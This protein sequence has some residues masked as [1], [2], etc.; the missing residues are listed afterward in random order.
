[1]HPQTKEG[2]SARGS[3]QLLLQALCAPLDRALRSFH[4]VQRTPGKSCSGP[5]P[6]SACSHQPQ[7]ARPGN[8]GH[9]AG[10]AAIPCP[11]HGPEQR[12]PSPGADVGLAA[13][14]EDGE[15]FLQEP[16]GPSPWPARLWPCPAVPVPAEHG[17]PG[18]M[19][20][21]EPAG[22]DIL[23]WNTRSPACP[24]PGALPRASQSPARTRDIGAA[25]KREAEGKPGVNIAMQDSFYCRG[26]AAGAR[27]DSGAMAKGLTWLCWPR[28]SSSSSPGRVLD[29][30]APRAPWGGSG[31]AGMRQRWLSSWHGAAE[32]QS[33]A[34]L[35]GFSCTQR[36]VGMVG[37]CRG[38]S[39]SS[40]CSEAAL[41]FSRARSCH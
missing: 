20:C 41:G 16:R 4:G 22:S 32:E 24:A 21:P 34:M 28:G 40:L 12:Q 39:C 3:S 36:R 35:E 9:A 2:T 37:M 30:R 8:L 33:P 29:S 25:G 15:E 5:S 38:F 31:G 10:I 11:F 19:W 13:V 26:R 17:Q 14:A 7:L 23:G 27:Q 18:G 1:M 6:P